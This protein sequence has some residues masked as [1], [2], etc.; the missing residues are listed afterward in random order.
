MSELKEGDIVMHF[1]TGEY[2]MILE[3]L[4]DEKIPG[5]TVRRSGDYGVMNVGEFEIGPVPQENAKHQ[6]NEVENGTK[7]N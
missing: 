2:M 4:T 1:L 7:N 3:A 5:F 6:L